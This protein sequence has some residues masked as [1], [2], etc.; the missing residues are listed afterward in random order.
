[1]LNGKS[2]GVVSKS[3]PS[4]RVPGLAFTG[5]EADLSSGVGRVFIGPPCFWISWWDIAGQ[6]GVL[7]PKLPMILS[8]M[9]GKV[10]NWMKLNAAK[11]FGTARFLHLCGAA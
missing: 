5:L 7:Q 1:M 8:V 10:R 11:D 3:V 2:C 9:A 6:Q 4:S